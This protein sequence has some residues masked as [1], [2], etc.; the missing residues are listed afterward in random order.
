MSVHEN[1]PLNAMLAPLFIL[2]ESELVKHYSVQ[3]LLTVDK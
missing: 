2:S 1:R 3:P